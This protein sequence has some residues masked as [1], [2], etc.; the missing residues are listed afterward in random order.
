MSACTVEQV[1][2]ELDAAKKKIV[3]Q[4]TELTKMQEEQ[5]RAAEAVEAAKAA[6]DR[7]AQEAATASVPA[8]SPGLPLGFGG[9]G[10]EPDEV[11]AMHALSGDKRLPRIGFYAKNDIA[12]GEELSYRR[13][14]SAFTKASWSEKLPTRHW[15][16]SSSRWLRI[17]V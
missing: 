13:D 8:L 9:G 5:R 6:R 3:A 15:A 17:L 2:G 10:Q 12:Q 14:A 4:E 1:V 11:R 7:E 16:Y